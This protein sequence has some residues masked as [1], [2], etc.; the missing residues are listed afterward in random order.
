MN[1]YLSPVL[2]QN[3]G[4]HKFKDAREVKAIVTRCVVTQD[5][6]ACRQG[7]FYTS[8]SHD[9]ISASAVA[10]TLWKSNGTALQLNVNCSFLS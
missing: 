8:L 2:K 6:D 4:G 1:C 10:R 5:T 7:M 9:A 3:L